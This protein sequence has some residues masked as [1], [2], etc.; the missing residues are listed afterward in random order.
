MQLRELS[1]TLGCAC[2]GLVAVFVTH[3]TMPRLGPLV[4]ADFPDAGDGGAGAAGSTYPGACTSTSTGETVAPGVYCGQELGLSP[5]AR[6]SCSA[7]NAAATLLGD[8][9]QGCTDPQAGSA[10]CIALCAGS[11][12]SFCGTAFGGDPNMLYVCSGGAAVT[13]TPCPFGCVQEDADSGV[14][15]GYDLCGDADDA[16]GVATGDAGAVPTVVLAAPADGAVAVQWSAETNPATGFTVTASPG[17]LKVQ[18]GPQARYAMV[19]GL[20]NGTAYTFW[21]QEDS[22]S[23]SKATAAVTPQAGAAIITDVP[24]IMPEHYGTCEI[25]A[26]AETLVHAGI[27]A[28][29]TDILNSVGVDETPAS[30]ANGV[31]T[32]GDPYASYVGNPDGNE[33]AMTGYGTYYSTIQRVALSLGVTVVAAG[34]GTSAASVYAAV[35]QG[36]PVITW[37]NHQWVSEPAAAAWHCDDGRTQTMNGLPLEYWGPFEH[38]FVVVGVSDDSIVVQTDTEPN[39]WTVYAKSDFEI[40]FAQFGNMAIVIQ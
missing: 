26:L 11:T 31:L 19:T 39:P 17:G 7:G 3:C 23:P 28:T 33:Q 15:P 25:A 36:H 12:G 30:L 4:L 8:C 34:E 13:S 10:L 27:A 5:A 29:Q 14:D 24:Y 32:W 20:T 1:G 38:A 40:G 37:V 2:V 22:G 18:V 6:Y 35:Q 21:V 16:G 9:A